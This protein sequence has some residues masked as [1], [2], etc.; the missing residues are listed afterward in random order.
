MVG[1]SSI[2]FSDC[3]HMLTPSRRYLQ[4]DLVAVAKGLTSLLCLDFEVKHCVTDSDPFP[5]K[6]HYLSCKIPTLRFLLLDQRL[7]FSTTPTRPGVLNWNQ[8][9][10][11]GLRFLHAKAHQNYWLNGRL[12]G[13]LEQHTAERVRT[14]YR[15]A[16]YETRL[17]VEG[18]RDSM[19]ARLEYSYLF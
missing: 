18:A 19:W 8:T 4:H 9:E 5:Q 11:C 7:K 2:P 15:T 3:V 13:A 1:T 6:V 10:M 14:A 17:M 16:T 12:G